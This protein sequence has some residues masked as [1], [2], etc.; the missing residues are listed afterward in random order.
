M[1]AGY[2]YDEGGILSPDGH[3]RAF[4]AQA[5]GTVVGNGVGIVVLKRLTDAIEDGD[6]IHAVILGSAVNNDGSQK[7]GYTAPSIQGQSTVIEDAV[8]ISEISPDSISYVEAHGTGTSIGDPIEITALTKAYRKW[9]SRKGYCAIGSVKTNI[10]HLDAGAGVTGV[11]KTVL[12]LENGLI[13]PSLNFHT[14]NPQI[15]FENS[16][17]YVNT[18]IATWPSNTAPR[19]AGVSSFG[20]GGTNAHIILEEAPKIEASMQSRPRQL[21]MLSAKSE[22]ALEHVTQRLIDHIKQNPQIN[23]ADVAYTLQTGRRAFNHRRM[24]VCQDPKDALAALDPIVP[25]RVVTSSTK[26]IEREIAFMF[27]GQG[28]QYVNMG[29]DLY[30]AEPIFKQQLDR[31][32]EILIPYIH[33]DLRQFLYP[34]EKDI[35]KATQWIQQTITAG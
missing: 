2:F 17:F 9:T 6:C 34:Q 28:S 25:K 35:E 21:L 13:P 16:P 20:L 22:A 1:S 15:D 4:D 19:R 32:C 18:K 30:N 27:S 24:V 31:C 5:R 12:A 10:G 8:A 14:P 26:S 23:L 7:I 11:I 29:L 33:L 3:C